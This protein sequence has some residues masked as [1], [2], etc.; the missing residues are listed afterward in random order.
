MENSTIQLGSTV[1]QSV[2][3]QQ[4]FRAYLAFRPVAGNRGGKPWLLG[5]GANRFRRA[6]SPGPVGKRARLNTGVEESGFEELGRS[7]AHR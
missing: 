1:A 4:C 7:G 3:V 2:A 5:G 6:E